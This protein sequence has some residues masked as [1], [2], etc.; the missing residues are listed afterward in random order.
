[1]TAMIAMNL[2][3]WVS[4][5]RHSAVR[6]PRTWAQFFCFAAVLWLVTGCGPGVGGTGV[7]ETQLSSFGATAA[8]VCTSSLAPALTCTISGT[9]TASSPSLPTAT[10]P[11]LL[12]GTATLVY[13]DTSRRVRLRLN[14]NRA[15]LDAACGPLSFTGE[16]GQVP[17]QSPRFYGA[18][19][20]AGSTAAA[21]ILV[22]VGASGL[23][24]TVFGENGQSLLGP[25]AL[26]TAPADSNL[27]TCGN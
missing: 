23:V 16:F 11:G 7:G 19:T 26:M 2:K 3:T 10:D 18:L 24:V 4:D 9:G 25:V 17:G 12:A 27:A 21:S 8:T 15:E 6:L 13:A 1:M 14:A 20:S 22:E 5:L